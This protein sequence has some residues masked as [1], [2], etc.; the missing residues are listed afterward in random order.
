MNTENNKATEAQWVIVPV[1][2]EVSGFVAVRA[3][4]VEDAVKMLKAEP[5]ISDDMPYLD[6]PDY[7][8][9][10]YEVNTN[11]DEIRAYTDMYAKGEL[12]D[13][14]FSTIATPAAKSLDAQ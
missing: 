9:W 10:S 5:D 7:V 13:V 1:S 6:A 2:Y 3:T 11:A 12:K 4:S 8:D 14:T